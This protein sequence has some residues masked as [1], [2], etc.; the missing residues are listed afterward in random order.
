MLRVIQ[1]PPPV[2][3]WPRRTLTAIQSRH[4]NYYLTSRVVVSDA[5]V[6]CWIHPVHLC[7]TPLQE[8]LG[9]L[10]RALEGIK[11]NAPAVTSRKEEVAETLRKL[12]AELLARTPP[13]PPP[14]GSL[15]FDNGE[16][17]FFLMPPFNR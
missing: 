6:S 16:I 14:T 4:W 5:F 12:D 1:H 11:R 15:E 13:L 3:E 17:P 9:V 10:R 8:E 7:I 2:M